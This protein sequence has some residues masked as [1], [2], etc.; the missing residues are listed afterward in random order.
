[1]GKIKMFIQDIIKNSYGIDELY[2]FLF[3]TS[4]I[5]WLLNI[6]LNSS[7][8]Y[9]L[10]MILLVISVFRVF[11]KNYEKRQQENM[12][13]IKIKNK[14][15]NFIKFENMKIKDRNMYIYRKCPKCKSNIRLPKKKGKHTC[16][17][18]CCKND[19]NVIC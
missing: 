14:V 8:I 12:K 1:M 4:I 15:V 19:F 11:S 16:M 9:Y 10:Y 7:F 3:G 18:P 13:Y 5:L 6:F 2:K 17:C